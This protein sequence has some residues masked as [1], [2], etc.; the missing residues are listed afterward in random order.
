MAVVFVD[1]YASAVKYSIQLNPVQVE[2]VFIQ[3]MIVIVI[4]KYIYVFIPV[5]QA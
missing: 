3:V 2:P 1:H 5:V 4:A